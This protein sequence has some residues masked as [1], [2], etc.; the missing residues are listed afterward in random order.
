MIY[1]YGLMDCCY[2]H[3]CYS[4]LT[5]IYMIHVYKYNSTLKFAFWQR[6]VTLITCIQPTWSMLVSS[7]WKYRSLDSG[8][9]SMTG[10]GGRSGG[11]LLLLAILVWSHVITIRFWKC[12]KSVRD[13]SCYV[14]VW[15][16]VSVNTDNYTHCIP[17][18]RAVNSTTWPD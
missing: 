9:D 1:W 14:L 3:G 8:S 12:V 2:I 18:V 13:K 7:G 11:S 5:V 15:L 16:N 10:R 6:N 17:E 4:F